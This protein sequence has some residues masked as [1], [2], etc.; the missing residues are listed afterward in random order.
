MMGSLDRS[1]RNERLFGAF[2]CQ[3]IHLPR[4]ARDKHGECWPKT[5]F[6]FCRIFSPLS[7]P[8]ARLRLHEH[9]RHWWENGAFVRFLYNNASFY[10]GR[11]G[12]N[13]GKA[14]KK[15][16]VFLQTCWPSRATASWCSVSL[17]PLSSPT[18]HCS[19]LCADTCMCTQIQSFSYNIYW[20]IIWLIYIYW[21]IIWYIY[22]DWLTIMMIQ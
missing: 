3:K 14:L 12:T 15:G 16:G 2:L 7:R 20:L 17:S 9:Q 8:A 10:Q 1:V 21:L 6:C 11:L 13:I 4:Q 18:A 22:I 19:L 5:R